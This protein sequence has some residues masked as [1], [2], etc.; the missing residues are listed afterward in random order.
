MPDQDLAQLFMSVEGSLGE[1]ALG[2]RFRNSSE[3]FYNSWCALGK[4]PDY[5]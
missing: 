5:Q 4:N 1:M 2:S 3:V